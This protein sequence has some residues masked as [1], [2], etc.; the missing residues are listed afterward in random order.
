MIG[1]GGLNLSE[2]VSGVL[3]IFKTKV[4]NSLL[5]VM[6]IDWNL[7]YGVLFD[8][9]LNITGDWKRVGYS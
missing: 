6:I 2:D 1:I 9:S 8:S 5:F 7:H 3:T 4:Y